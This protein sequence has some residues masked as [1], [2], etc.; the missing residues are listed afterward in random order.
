MSLD[1]ITILVNKGCCRHSAIMLQLPQQWALRELRMEAGCLPSD[2]QT[3]Q[4]PRRCTLRRLKMRKHRILAPDSWA[5]RLLNLPICRKVLNSL[6]WDIW[7]SLI[8]N[9]FLMFWLPGLCCK[10]SY[11][12]PGSP[13]CLF[14]AVSQSC[15]RCCVLGWNPQF[16]HWRKHNSQLKK[17]FCIYLLFNLFLA[18]LGI[19][20]FM[21]FS[22][23]A[24]SGDYSLAAVGGLLT[25]VASLLVEHGL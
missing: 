18:V 14:G 12:F 10:N 4:Q 7:F 19:R 22:L 11:I 9:N 25:A 21:G 20:C 17:N 2:H 16:F 23:V 8:I 24:A 1:W 6:T 3:L 15:L 5:A 13:F